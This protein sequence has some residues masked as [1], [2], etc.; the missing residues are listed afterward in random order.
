LAAATAVA[1][2]LLI[3]ASQARLAP[4]E[5]A[6]IQPRLY[7]TLAGDLAMPI[8]AW[9]VIKSINKRRRTDRHEP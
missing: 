9:F 4:E 7:G 5:F 3:Q 2:L 1:M 6:R 8:I